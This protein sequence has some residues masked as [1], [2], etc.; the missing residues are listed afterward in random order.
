[1][2]EIIQ[3]GASIGLGIGIGLIIIGFAGIAILGAAVYALAI[4]DWFK[5]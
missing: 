2:M 4:I 5:K 3:F 1:M